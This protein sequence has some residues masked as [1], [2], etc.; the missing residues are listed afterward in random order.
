MLYHLLKCHLLLNLHRLYYQLLHLNPLLQDRLILYYLFLCHQDF[1]HLLLSLI[2]YYHLRSNLNHLQ[3]YRL[4]P[5]LL[6]MNNLQ[7]HLLIH[8]TLQFHLH[9][10][11]LKSQLNHLQYLYLYFLLNHLLLLIHL[12]LHFQPPN[13]HLLHLLHRLH[14]LL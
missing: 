7:S 3:Q 10:L 11:N 5:N 13:P 2:L 6:T 12:L 1:N 4:L 9:Y 8:L 14:L